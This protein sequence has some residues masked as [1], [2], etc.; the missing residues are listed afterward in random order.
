MNNPFS[1][2]S[3]TAWLA[4]PQR[5]TPNKRKDQPLSLPRAKVPKTIQPRYDKPQ[6]KEAPFIPKAKEDLAVQ[7]SVQPR[8][9]PKVELPKPVAISRQTVVGQHKN[10]AQLKA[11]FESPKHRAVVLWGSTGT[12]KTMAAHE[13]PGNIV[14]FNPL[15]CHIHAD[16]TRSLTSCGAFGK[17]VVLLD[18]VD[19]M[20]SS[21]LAD[22]ISVMNQL[23][24][25]P[26]NP[27]VITCTSLHTLPPCLTKNS[28][29]LHFARVQ[30]APMRELLLSLA[31]GPA[32]NLEQIISLANGD[33][34]QALSMLYHG[35]D[36][37]DLSG[38]PFQMVL[39]AMNRRPRV[40]PC[41]LLVKDPPQPWTLP[42]KAPTLTR[43][44]V[45]M[46]LINTQ[47]LPT[48]KNSDFMNLFGE[49]EACIF[50]YYLV[51]RH[52]LVEKPGAKDY[53]ARR[54]WPFEQAFI[55]CAPDLSDWRWLMDGA[56]LAQDVQTI[57]MKELPSLML[58]LTM[59]NA[60]L[61]PREVKDTA[62]T[63]LWRPRT[64]FDACDD[65]VQ[66]IN[67]MRI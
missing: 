10:M 55:A 43:A 45:P 19:V 4:H 39:A 61:N 27:L 67:R 53:L 25:L 8:A 2:F 44:R 36:T 47:G 14:E 59:S 58:T 41:V 42:F 29:V 9:E 30:P 24:A 13:L 62:H 17:L 31:T 60:R 22:V 46:P 26:I 40:G 38:S 51:P 54:V 16:L 32:A 65:L 28:L 20:P 15:S 48:V 50:A 37:K 23:S 34:R 12:G 52:T 56:S 7:L 33:V 6:P 21:V 11:W 1:P 64:K 5:S 66:R 35:S 3:R 63:A 49:F 18:D 57:A